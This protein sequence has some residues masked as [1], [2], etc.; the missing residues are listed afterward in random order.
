MAQRYKMFVFLFI[1]YFL[2][3]DNYINCDKYATNITL[4]ILHLVIVIVHLQISQYTDIT[5][6]LVFGLK[7]VCRSLKEW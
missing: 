2:P 7:E 4:V 1:I 3:P 5:V 6:E